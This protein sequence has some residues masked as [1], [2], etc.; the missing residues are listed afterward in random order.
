MTLQVVYSVSAGVTSDISTRVFM[1]S[2]RLGLPAFAITLNAEEGSVGM[3]SLVVDDPSG[4]LVL[5]GHRRIYFVETAAPTGQQVIGNTYVGKKAVSRGDWRVGPLARTY[6][7]ILA[8]ANTLISRRIVVGSDGS[9]P[10]ETDV[11]RVQWLMTTTEANEF[12]G[13][14]TYISTDSPISMDAVDYRGQSV[15]NILNDCSQAS[16]KNYWVIYEESLGEFSLW[17]DWDYSATYSSIIRLS[18]D[19]ADIDDTTTFAY[20]PSATLTQDPER[21]YSGTYL[22]FDGGWVY[23]QQVSTGNRFVFRDVSYPSFNVKSETKA[24]A[25]AVRYNADSASEDDVVSL[26]FV[27]PAGNVNSLMH[28]HRIEVKGTHWGF[29]G[30]NDYTS[31]TWMRA[32]NRTVTQIGPNHYRIDAELSAIRPGTCPNV[33]PTPTGYYSALLPL[34]IPEF[35]SFPNTLNALTEYTKGGTPYSYPSPNAWNFPGYRWAGG[36]HGGLVDI[37]MSNVGNKIFLYPKGD[38]TIT[39]YTVNYY[40]G[41]GATFR[42]RLLD[43]VGDVIETVGTNIPMGTP[44]TFDVTLARDGACEHVIAVDEWYGGP[45]VPTNH[46]GWDGFDW[47]STA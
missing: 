2:E 23:E 6:S 47:V 39:L 25:R 43:A 16:G 27:V 12:N 34:P 4:N 17:Y 28:G 5:N 24:R 7:V 19:E 10:A 33:T 44:Y 8:D 13:S 45:A 22:P 37:G 21:V 41:A 14:T 18:N 29:T 11:Q 31:F 9:R 40:G 38:G 32:L 42:V 1:A 3:S 36:T 46:L 15:E 35:D 20:F 30:G 26:S